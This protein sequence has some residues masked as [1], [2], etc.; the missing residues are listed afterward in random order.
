MGALNV[1]FV[2]ECRRNVRD[3]EIKCVGTA[4]LCR[5]WWEHEGVTWEVVTQRLHQIETGVFRVLGSEK[6]PGLSPE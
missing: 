5:W 2:V 4:A 3:D 6:S 1:M